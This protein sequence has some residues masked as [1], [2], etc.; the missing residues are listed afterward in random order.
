MAEFKFFCPQCGQRI[1]CD[2]SYSGRQINCPVC[3]QIIVVP[4]PPRADGATPVPVKSKTMRKVLV[5]AA[6]VVALAGV[7]AGG[8]FGYSEIKLHIM[9]PGLINVDFGGGGGRGNSLKTGFAAIGRSAGDFWNFYDRDASSAPR[10]WRKSGT[11]TNLKLANGKQTRVGMSVSDAPG[12]YSKGSTDEMYKVF[13]YPLD[14]GN[15]IV[16]FKNLPAGRYD[17]LAYSPDG[18]FEVT[19]GGTSYGVKKTYDSPVSDIPIW[20]EG[21]QYARFRS[22]TVKAGQSLILTVRNGA[23]NPALLSG[24]QISSEAF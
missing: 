1:Q 13:D 19:V 10:D 17:V 3:Q 21:I 11:L 16:T 5:I 20:K 18:N 23:S 6:L 15:D 7:I 8:W 12:A 22:V 4:Q 24:V 14:G 2:I 9:P